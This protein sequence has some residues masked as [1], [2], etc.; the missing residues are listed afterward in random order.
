MRKKLLIIEDNRQV[1]EILA[2]ALGREGYQIIRAGNGSAGLRMAEERSPDLVLIDLTQAEPD[3]FTVCRELR[4]AGI[5]VPVILFLSSEEQVDDLSSID[6]NDSYIQYIQKPFQM[7][8]LLMQVKVNTWELESVAFE[9]DTAA[10]LFFGRL[11]IDPAQVLVT[12]DDTPIE[13]TQTE[14]DLLYYLAQEPGKVISRKELLEKV[15]GYFY[16]G[17]TRNVDVCIRRLREKLEDDPSHPTII[18]TRRGH[19][20]VF[21]G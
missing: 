12:K 13:L 1:L 2:F 8:E 15:W 4:E 18:V 21:I 5:E 20:Y 17:E 19:G 11:I 6:L 9:A 16:M 14:Y 7:Q 10:R 3:S